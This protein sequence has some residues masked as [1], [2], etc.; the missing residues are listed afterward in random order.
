MVPAHPPATAHRIL[1][2]VEQWEG[3]RDRLRA[4]ALARGWTALGV[5]GVEPLAD[6][7]RRGLHAV[8]AGRMDGMAWMTADRVRASTDIGA[9]YPWARSIVALAWPY[10][11]VTPAPA[12]APGRPAGRMAAYACMSDPAVGGGASDYHEVLGERCDQLVEWLRGQVGEVRAKRFIDHGWAMD[13]AIAERAGIGFTGKHASLITAS[14]GSYVLLA[15]IA[16]SVPLPADAPSKKACG[17][18]RSCLPAC[19]TGAI[20]A[21]GMIDARR[22]ISYLTIEHEGAIDEEL[23]PLMG[24]W[25]FGC[26]LC[27]EACPINHRRAPAPLAAAEPPRHGPVPAPDLVELL[28]LSEADFASRYA[29]SSVQRSGRGRLARNAAIALGNAGDIAA[30]PA[31]RRAAAA[32]PDPVVREAADWAL[33]QLEPAPTTP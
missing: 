24:T 5:T 29:G 4:E 27:Q 2:R 22:C 33:H 16:L 3:V 13:R 15:E 1:V 25:V 20:V 17:T 8:A 23:R 10:R 31:L 7:R 9:R 32:D 18:C 28:S 6:A 14:A 21:P 26:D 19:P 30:A 12:R 11:P